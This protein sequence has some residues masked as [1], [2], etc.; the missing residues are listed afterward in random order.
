M[1]TTVKVQRNNL[2][3]PQKETALLPGWYFG[4]VRG[5]SEVLILVVGSNPNRIRF[6]PLGVNA[7]TL[8]STY[9]V[10]DGTYC[11]VVPVDVTIEVNIQ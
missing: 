9:P 4:Q 1:S 6:F 10:H 3:K 7:D 2:P 5:Y 11:I 8:T